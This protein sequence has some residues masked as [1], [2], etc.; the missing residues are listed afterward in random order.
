M[1][2]PFRNKADNRSYASAEDA[3]TSEGG[4]LSRE[5]DVPENDAEREVRDPSRD[6]STVIGRYA[7]GIRAALTAFRVPC[8]RR[9][10]PFRKRGNVQ[11]QS[12]VP[13]NIVGAT[14]S[15]ASSREEPS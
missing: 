9:T 4:H 2:A 5:V 6:F 13:Y 15:I 1:V 3:F 8:T 12:A 7:E 10:T 14:S 11:T